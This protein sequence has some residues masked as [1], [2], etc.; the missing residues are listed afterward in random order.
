MEKYPGI[1]TSIVGGQSYEGREILGVKVSFGPGRK[2]VFIESG[3]HAREWIA[4]ATVTYILNEFLS[5]KNAS[6]RAVAESRDW[7]FFP[8]INPD[9]YS[10]TQTVNKPFSL[11][12]KKNHFLCNCRTECGGR[13]G[14]RMRNVLEL[15]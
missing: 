15:I 13:I 5:S 11:L 3:I 8:S 10:Y 4:P 6:V 1:V 9:G 2:G 14:D 7:Y 12:F